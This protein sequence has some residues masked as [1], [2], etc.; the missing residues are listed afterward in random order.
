MAGHLKTP[1][2]VGIEVGAQFCKG[3]RHFKVS[4]NKSSPGRWRD[5]CS[6]RLSKRL[7]R[8]TISGGLRLA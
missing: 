7:V 5:L 4:V 6:V 3:D 1:D 2:R 8:W